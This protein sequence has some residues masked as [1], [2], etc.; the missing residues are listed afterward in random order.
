[1][2]RVAIEEARQGLAE[3]GIPI[4]A[5]LFARQGRLLGRGHNRRVQENDP[6]VH[7]ETDAFR[8]AGRQRSYR[9]TSVRMA[10]EHVPKGDTGLK[11]SIFNPA[12]EGLTSR[13]SGSGGS[14]TATTSS[15][16]LPLRPA[17]RALARGGSSPGT[18]PVG[19]LSLTISAKPY[20]LIARA[21]VVGAQPFMIMPSRV[22][23]A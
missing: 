1:M 20:S 6:S 8:K 18:D 3:G 10:H 16:G 19:S 15:R 14:V 17:F 9:E 21:S 11:H 5:A 12:S 4:G 2:L 7:G 23:A 13:R 22:E